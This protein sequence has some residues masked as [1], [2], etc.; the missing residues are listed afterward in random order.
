MTRRTRVIAYVTRENPQSG[1]DELLVFDVLDQPGFVGVIPGGGVEPGEA[2]EEAV[3]RETLEETGLGVR[4]VRPVGFAE[5][6][7]RR[8]ASLLHETHFFQATPVGPTREAWEH[9]IAKQ[10]GSIEEGPVRC[11]WVQVRPDVELWGVNRGAF[12]DAL[13]R[14]RVV[15]YVTRERNGRAEL[16]TIAAKDHPEVGIE[17]PA[18]RL[19]FGETLEEG[20][21]RELAEETGLS[22]VRIVRELTEFESSYQSFC[23]N[24]AFH[25]V[26]EQET[27][28]EWE[29]EVHGDGVDSGM[30]HL[31]RWV[32]LTEDLELWN[33]RDPMLAKLPI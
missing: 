13:V 21:R 22:G 26:L 11:R 24:H 23:E 32:P 27:P 16:L 6:P 29:H 4:V 2:L 14:Q 33:A 20:L 5:Q 3:V 9:R 31:C 28:D 1:V 25:V 18:G 17:V 10:D 19:D 15:A 8:D 12:V 30:I 7:G